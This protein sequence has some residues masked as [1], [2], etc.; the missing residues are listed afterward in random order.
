[1]KRSRGGAIIAIG[2]LV[3][4]IAVLILQSFINQ[5]TTMPQPTVPIPFDLQTG[6]ASQGNMHYIPLNLSGDLHE[7]I[8]VVLTRIDNWEKD[9]PNKEILEIDYIWTFDTYLY[10]AETKGIIIRTRTNN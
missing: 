7:N 6:I 2:S 9:N 3:I 1:M 8:G 10:E 5:E 4:V